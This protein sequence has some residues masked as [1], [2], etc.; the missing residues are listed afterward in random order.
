ML[1]LTA[2]REARIKTALD[3]LYRFFGVTES[4][5]QRI[6]RG[7]YGSAEQVNVPKIT[8]SRR[9]F[10]RMNSEEQ[11]EYERKLSETKVEYRLI[12]KADPDR[13]TSVPKMVHDW[14]VDFKE[15]TDA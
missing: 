8:Y 12:Y 10:N 14:F 15:K 1:Y 11:A 5:R 6:E 7:V 4:F 9:K 3:K 13:F 2:A